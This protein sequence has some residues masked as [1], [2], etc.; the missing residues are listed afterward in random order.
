MTCSSSRGTAASDRLFRYKRNTLEG[1]NGQKTGGKG[2]GKKKSANGDNKVAQV[3]KQQQKQLNQE[4][5]LMAILKS[6][7]ARLE[8]KLEAMENR[9]KANNQRLK[10]LTTGARVAAKTPGAMAADSFPRVKSASVVPYLRSLLLPSTGP[11]DIPDDVIRQHMNKSDTT[12]RN[13]AVN[14][15]GQGIFLLLPNFP[16]PLVGWHYHFNGTV[17]A[18][19]GALVTSQDF[20]LNF[21]YGRKISSE[22]LI[23]SSTLPG[24]VYALNGTFNAVKVNGTFSEVGSSTTAFGYNEILSA[25]SDPFAKI[26][27]AL[28][29]DGV[30]VLMLPDSFANP[31]FRMADVTPSSTL[32]GTLNVAKINNAAESLIYRTMVT[33]TGRT[34]PTDSTQI[35]MLDWTINIDASVGTTTL[36]NIIITSASGQT[37]AEMAVSV[38]YR[39]P[40][41][42]VINSEVA[43]RGVVAFSTLNN[44]VVPF[45]DHKLVNYYPGTSPLG[46]FPNG[47]PPIGSIQVYVNMWKL[48]T[49]GT[50]TVSCVGDCTIESWSGGKPGVCQ[51]V[52]VVAYQGVA[53]GSV[54][55]VSGVANFELVPNPELRKNVEVHYSQFADGEMDYTKAIMAHR[56]QVGIRAVWNEKEYQRDR[57]IFEELARV[58]EHQLAQALDFGPIVA[59]LKK[60][61]L[62]I[63]YRALPETQA[64]G[65]GLSALYDRFAPSSAQA[66]SGIVLTHAFDVPPV[67]SM[68]SR[69]SRQ[70]RLSFAEAMMEWYGDDYVLAMDMPAPHPTRYQR[71]MNQRRAQP[72]DAPFKCVQCRSAPTLRPGTSCNE[73]AV[74]VELP[75]DGSVY[76]ITDD[77]RIAW[78]ADGPLSYKQRVGLLRSLRIG[79]VNLHST[80][81]P[82]VVSVERAVFFP[83]ITIDSRGEPN[84]FAMYIAVPGDLSALISPA[85]RGAKAFQYSNGK[86]KIFGLRNSDAYTFVGD[87]KGDV[88]LLCVVPRNTADLTVVDGPLV[89]AHSCDAAIWLASNGHFSGL[90]KTAITGRL[91]L[92]GGSLNVAPNEAFTEKQAFCHAVGIPLAGNSDTADFRV[93]NIAVHA[94]G[95]VTIPTPP[96]HRVIAPTVCEVIG[97]DYMG[98]LARDSLGSR[99]RSLGGSHLA[100]A[101]D[102]NDF[103]IVRSILNDA[104]TLRA[105]GQQLD[106]RKKKD[107][108]DRL[109]R[110]HNQAIFIRMEAI[111]D[112]DDP[113]AAATLC[114]QTLRA[115]G[116]HQPPIPG[117][118]VAVGAPHAGAQAHAEG[119]APLGAPPAN[120]E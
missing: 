103:G 34:V 48:V 80:A 68:V 26:G 6:T 62:P 17:Y 43:F 94:D 75:M 42:N 8:Q 41:G 69:H 65:E 63:L 35:T 108:Q 100:L 116:P 12:T 79:A 86:H 2:K 97:G 93:N 104:V 73:C 33:G 1:T 90:M 52:A 5:K 107:F 27:N 74:L 21:D 64:I 98:A 16:G 20:A 14:A 83:T 111:D 36:G 89:G 38:V 59:T 22:V 9:L 24:G 53:T 19:S 57:P 92:D 66:A 46:G 117:P 31:Y 54:M 114:K 60:H 37:A 4:H 23:R 56:D 78:A 109:R 18:L 88:T 105:E 87:L 85:N 115:F 71:C 106:A 112:V 25:T 10:Q 44:T 30:K 55:T 67:E 47:E 51:P 32:Q 61:F 82:R 99:F 7:D 70:R 13:I 50:Q 28:V 72:H 118:G 81:G 110:I 39:D 15:E 119:V 84:G 91:E 49:T 11:A 77:S 3:Q 40:F 29:G 45:A 58:G 76:E 113:D 101:M 95:F 120:V 96:L 102:Q